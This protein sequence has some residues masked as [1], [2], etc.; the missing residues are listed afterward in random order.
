MIKLYTDFLT[1]SRN[2]DPYIDAFLRRHPKVSI[3]ITGS[4][5]TKINQFHRCF[6][7]HQVNCGTEDDVCVKTAETSRMHFSDLRE[8]TSLFQFDLIGA[9]NNP[10]ILGSPDIDYNITTTVNVST[11]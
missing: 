6:E 5:P 3:D 1:D 4:S 11:V 7:T 8:P 2:F 10:C 9:A